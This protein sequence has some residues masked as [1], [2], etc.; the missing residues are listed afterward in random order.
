MMKMD[1][2]ASDRRKRFSDGTNPILYK[3]IVLDGRR[4][5]LASAEK[6][7]GAAARSGCATR[8]RFSDGTNPILYECIVL[9][10]R[11][12]ALGSAEKSLGASSQEWL[13]HKEA[14]F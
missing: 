13:R 14:L 7:L 3:C 12:T 10:G 8:K 4:A 5:A 2:S 11:R 1:E 6:S 9:N